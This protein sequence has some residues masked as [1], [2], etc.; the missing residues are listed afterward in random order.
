CARVPLERRVSVGA[1]RHAPR[2]ARRT[3]R[4][5]CRPAVR[6]AQ[7][8]G[9][10]LRKERELGLALAAEHGEVDGCYPDPALLGGG[11]RLRL[12]LLRGED[13]AAVA[14]RRIEAD[15]VEVAR[16]LLDGVDRADA[17]DLDGDPAVI[18]V[19]A[20]QVDGTDVRRPLALDE[21]QPRL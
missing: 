14:A 10:A 17:L 8:G 2:P 15:A 21:P 11:H 13:A 9:N 6:P 19:A 4:A 16:E 5:L 7:G 1:A 12:E 3:A 20:H 18:L